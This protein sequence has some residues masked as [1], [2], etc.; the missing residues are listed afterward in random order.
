MIT[1]SKSINNNNSADN[2]TII[3]QSMQNMRESIYN[4]YDGQ[5]VCT[6]RDMSMSEYYEDAMNNNSHNINLYLQ[7]LYDLGCSLMTLQ[8]VEKD[9]NNGFKLNEKFGDYHDWSFSEKNVV[10]N[11]NFLKKMGHH[12]Y[13]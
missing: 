2:N 6:A 10:D 8:I 12:L 3:D 13:I 11:C 7:H 4:F 5:Q 9:S 1:R